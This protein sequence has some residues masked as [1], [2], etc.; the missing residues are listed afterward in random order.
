MIH[1]VPDSLEA[2]SE[3]YL[4]LAGVRSA[5]IA[6]KITLHLARFATFFRQRYGHDR[7]SA[8]VRRDVVA[9]QSA[10]REQGLAPATITTTWPRSRRS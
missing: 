8:C 9:W 3:C 10:L 4:A 6:D 1:D 2:W 7:L 5:G